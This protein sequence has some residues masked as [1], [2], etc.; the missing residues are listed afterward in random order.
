MTM[1]LRI[2]CIL[3][4][5]A[6]LL[7]S[8]VALSFE[9]TEH[10][11]FRRNR[12]ARK[13]IDENGVIS[14]EAKE[15]IELGRQYLESLWDSLDKNN[16]RKLEEGRMR[17]LESMMSMLPMSMTPPVGKPTQNPPSPTTPPKPTPAPV[18]GPT[19]P[20]RE[21]I[22][23]RPPTPAPSTAQ[24]IAPSTAKPTKAPTPTKAPVAPDLPLTGG[25]VPMG[26]CEGVAKDVY[27]LDVLTRM[28]AASNVLSR[29]RP[30][31]DK[32]TPQGKAALF[33][34]DENPSYM[35]SP[36]LIQ[37]YALSTFYFALGGSSWTNNKGWL[38]KTHECNWY[39]VE[40][41]EDKIATGLNLG[42]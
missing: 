28:T 19:L 16:D 5:H 2:P 11:I 37:R 42:K 10:N 14:N 36:T 9:E 41:N 21:P 12:V 34:L 6:L 24:P 38:E 32:N 7:C 1:G 35:C 33:L 4:I 22:P 23:T 17:Y 15:D 18:R 39:G 27:L 25:F 26:P 13:R 3:T 20:T 30:F 29:D 8:H 40:C 31:F